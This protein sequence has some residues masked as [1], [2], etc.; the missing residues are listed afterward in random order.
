MARQALTITGA[1]VGS[2][3]GAPQ[4]GLAIGSAIGGLVD[5][6]VIRAPSVRDVAT[7]TAQE[8]VPCPLYDGT[9]GGSG[10]MVYCSPPKFVK[11]RKRQG[12]GGP[13][14]ESE[15]IILPV[16]VIRVGAALRDGPGQ[17]VGIPNLIKVW[18]DDKL[19]YDVSP[20]SQ[21]LAESAEY[22]KGFDYY[23][24]DETQLPDP[25]LEA[26][27]GATNAVAFR[28]RAVFMRKNYDATD[29]RGAPPIFKFEVATAAQQV[30]AVALVSDNRHYSGAP[31]DLVPAAS[32][33]GF[34]NEVNNVRLTSDGMVV[35]G[36]II[37]GPSG[38]ARFSIRIFDPELQS[39]SA[40]PTPSVM[41]TWGPRAMAWSPKL[42]D[43]TYYLAIGVNWPGERLWVYRWDGS[44]LTKLPDPV[45]TL[46]NGTPIWALAWNE[47]GTKLAAGN[48]SS[49]DGVYVW[50]FVGEALVN[51]RALAS[52][53]TNPI[54]GAPFRLDWYV[55]RLAC[56]NSTAAFVVDTDSTPMQIIDSATFDV[57]VGVCQGCY[58]SADFSHVVVVD[59]DDVY[60]FAYDA[61]AET[62]TLVGSYNILASAA[63]DS[64]IDSTRR[65]I[66]V[67]ENTGNIE[68]VYLGATD[69]PVPTVVDSIGSTNAFSVSFV[70]EPLI[71]QI[72][73]GSTNFQQAV[74]AAGR[75]CGMVNGDWDV[76][77][78]TGLPIRGTVVA[79]QSY[80]GQDFVNGLRIA[81]PSDGACFGGKIHI[82]KRG[83]AIDFELDDDFRV[84]EESDAE[85]DEVLRNGDDQRQAQLRRPAKINL[86]FPNRNLGYTFTKANAPNYG[87]PQGV[88]AEVQVEV[89]VVLDEETE[90]PQLA[91]VLDKISRTEAEGEVVRV[92]PDYL[93]GKAVPGTVIRLRNGADQRR[94]RVATV[95]AG[96]GV[97]RLALWAD[98]Q[99]AYTSQASAPSSAGWPTPPP[100]LVGETVAAFFNLPALIDDHD[101]LGV[102]AAI[103]GQPNTAWYGARIEYRVLGMTTWEDLGTFSQ[104]TVMGTLLDPLPAASPFWPDWTNPLRVRLLQ[105]D[106]LESL[107]EAEWLSEMGAV[108]IRRAD[109]TAEVLQPQFAVNDSGQDWTLTNHQRGRLE[110][111]ATAHAA[112]ARLVVLDGCIFLPLPASALGL[113]LEFR[114]TALGSSPETAPI[115]TLLWNPPLVQREFTVAGLTLTR[116]G[117]RITGSWLPRGRFGV[118]SNPI[119]SVNLDGYLVTLTDGTTTRTV[120]AATPVLDEPDAAFAGPVTVTVQANNRFTGPGPGISE[121]V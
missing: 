25:D 116:A 10:N 51:R 115:H 84:E 108:A 7:Q 14:V 4:L 106:E 79:S 49:V 99:H 36:S 48:N 112:G 103:S 38:A 41:P 17:R 93:A 35:A 2:F 68:M 15:R 50:D 85:Q 33:I 111:G 113:T 58:W 53:G 114:V 66:A 34:E 102:Y 54:G 46:P 37:D 110:T 61:I 71:D 16:V 52:P 100:S 78:M 121:T 74:L 91:D 98:R 26:V 44:S 23:P 118:D 70:G 13:V 109:G 117:G 81:H 107:T 105:D 64:S 21:I 67:A 77:E 19:V 27:L 5:P 96:E 43:G 9:V 94:L 57:D 11:Q 20:T 18:E 65:Y 72:E 40:G 55:N 60:T 92:F 3:F 47:N 101:R 45:D 42:P 29:R 89:P 87:A 63:S 83:G 73:A 104:R 6:Q 39:W 28:G 1:I 56:A 95:R 119:Q 69:V 62:L 76:S 8:G 30:S 75:R 22:A 24:G 80:T 120:T 86:L 32:T 59:S 12:K 90:A 88:V 31:A 97:R 82:L